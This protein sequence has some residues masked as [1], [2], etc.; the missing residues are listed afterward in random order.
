MNVQLL[1]KFG[2]DVNAQDMRGHAPLHLAVMGIASMPDEYSQLKKIVKELL[3]SG[4]NRELETDQGLTA[5]DLL[6]DI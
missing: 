6:D 3:F 2:A 1:I 4:A 5:R